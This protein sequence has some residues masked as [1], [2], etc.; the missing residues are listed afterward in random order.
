MT[1]EICGALKGCICCVFHA[2]MW[3][4]QPESDEHSEDF[5]EES[6]K[7]E[8]STGFTSSLSKE[9]KPH[10]YHLTVMTLSKR[11]KVEGML[12]CNCLIHTWCFIITS[13][14]QIVFGC[15]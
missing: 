1:I 7:A 9:T 8:E 14:S 10:D 2:Q 5:K 11:G 12:L 3:Y 13:L 15:K 6:L 4:E